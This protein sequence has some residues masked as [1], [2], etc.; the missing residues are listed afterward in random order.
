MGFKRDLYPNSHRSSNIRS[1]S[2]SSGGSGSEVDLRAEFDEIV[3]GGP[4]SI[5]HGKKVMLRKARVD[6]DFIPKSCV[7]K[8]T[9]T[10][11][12]DFECPFCLGEGF[13]WDEE[14]ATCY[15]VYIGADGGLSGRIK[16]LFPG[17]LRV[18][19]KVFYFRYDT[20]ISYR[21]KIVELQLDTEGDIVVPYHREAIYKPQTINKYRSD[22][23]R[24][25][26]IAVYCREND[27][28]RLDK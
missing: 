16:Q 19:T 17:Q 3:F 4:T 26:Y 15:S 27:A 12:P 25:E 14:F 2:S 9:L 22:Y 24:V 11:E 8:D 6:S 28:I 20:E 13:Y 10:S 5:P 21:D 1:S 18:D 7:C 23:G